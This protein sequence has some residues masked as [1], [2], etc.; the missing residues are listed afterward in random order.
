M[1]ISSLFKI[2]KYHLVLCLFIIF[3][4]EKHDYIEENIK[5][6]FKEYNYNGKALIY[7]D[8]SNMQFKD[9]KSYF[10][11]NGKD[12]LKKLDEDFFLVDVSQNKSKMTVSIFSFKTGKAIIC[13]FNKSTLTSK[14]I[15]DIKMGESKPYYIY[16]EI[17]KRKYPNYMNWDMFPIP[18]DSLK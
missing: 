16:Y 4:C 18:K 13:H 9:T 1:N 3:S 10:F 2:N 11:M 15:E 5:Q 8:K 6:S 12:I 14:E 17:L 7:R